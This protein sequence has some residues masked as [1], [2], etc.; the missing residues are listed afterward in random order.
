MVSPR[1]LRRLLRE[2]QE[3][4]GVCSAP[5]NK[6]HPSPRAEG[7]EGHSVV[8]AWRESLARSGRTTRAA[9]VRKHPRPGCWV[10][11]SPAPRGSSVHFLP[12]LR[13]VSQA[14][15]ATPPVPE[16]SIQA[17]GHSG[18][19]RQ[20]RG[21]PSRPLYTL[22]VGVQRGCCHILHQP[23]RPSGGLPA[24]LDPASSGPALLLLR[25]LRRRRTGGPAP[26]C[27]LPVPPPACSAGRR[28]QA[29]T[30]PRAHGRLPGAWA[31]AASARTPPV[32]A[33][34]VLP[35]TRAFTTG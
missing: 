15:L 32:P 26:R 20:V 29:A 22:P 21:R 11:T 2:A 12:G 6:Q 19:T 9:E 5:P 16:E 7:P 1:R 34:L 33:R 13:P 28:A 31:R 18:P 30:E 10:L 27:L 4:S 17:R 23:R 35:C 14:R 3:S 24:P 25:L 8:T